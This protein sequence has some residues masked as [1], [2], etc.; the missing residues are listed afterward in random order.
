[1]N[2]TVKGKNAHFPG[3]ANYWERRYK[4]GGNSGDGSYGSLA[5]FK[6]DV[7]NSFVE[8]NQIKSVIDFGCGDGNQTKLANYP[9]YLGF[10]VSQKAIENCKK[11]FS[12][13]N[14]KVFML[15]K[16]YNGEE[17]ELAISLDVIYH[18]IEDQ[19]FHDYMQLLFNASQ[20][21]VIIYSSNYDLK[22]ESNSHMRHREFTKWISTYCDNWHLIRNIEQK[23]PQRTSA[24]FYIYKRE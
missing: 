11:I 16:D 19:V 21:Y 8:S 24:E 12:D 20:K 7:L 9:N 5:D 4:D 13:D 17:A 23:Y 15:M 2:I 22:Y 10:D 14:K 1:M 18:L 3:S 6:A